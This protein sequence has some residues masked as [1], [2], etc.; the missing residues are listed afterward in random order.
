MVFNVVFDI[1]W[2][3]VSGVVL[4]IVFDGVLWIMCGYLFNVF[5]KCFDL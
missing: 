1:L 4:V 5:G 3:F 2:I